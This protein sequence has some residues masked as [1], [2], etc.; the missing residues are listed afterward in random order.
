[1][2]PAGLDP[3]DPDAQRLL[4]LEAKLKKARGTEPVQQRAQVSGLDMAY[5]L[6]AELVAA[7]LVGLALGWGL[8]RLFGT[9]PVL[10]IVMSLFGIVAGILGVFRTAAG[11]NA[12][13]DRGGRE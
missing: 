5:R 2:A 7:V 3:N 11:M 1:M 9:A 10:L 4:E 6:L 8:D 13:S 12:K